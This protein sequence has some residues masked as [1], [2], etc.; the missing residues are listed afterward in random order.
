MRDAFA[1]GLITRAS[2]IQIHSTG[3][4]LQVARTGESNEMDVLTMLLN[5][6]ERPARIAQVPDRLSALV[7]V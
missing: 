2:I 6:S 3:N 1:R 5:R 4:T 7:N